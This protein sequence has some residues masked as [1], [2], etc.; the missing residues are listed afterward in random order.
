MLLRHAVLFLIVL[1]TALTVSAWPTEQFIPGPK[2]GEFGYPPAGYED[3]DPGTVLKVKKI[4]P[5][6][7]GISKINATGYKV[8]YRSSARSPSEPM[9]ATMMLLV[10]HNPDTGKVI[11][12]APPED[13]PATECAPSNVYKK[14]KH[15]DTSNLFAR[16]DLLMINVHLQNGMVVIVPDYEGPNA[17]F[18]VGT[19]SGH[20]ILDAARAAKNLPD[21][22]LNDNV[23]FVAMGYSGGGFAVA[24]AAQLHGSYANDVNLVGAAIG[25]APV[26]VTDHIVYND[27]ERKGA[28]II[29]AMTG[30]FNGNPDAAREVPKYFNKRGLAGMYWARSHCSSFKQKKK[31]IHLKRTSDAFLKGGRKFADI[32]FLV[33][34]AEKN[35]LGH[36]DDSAPNVPVFMYHI[37]DDDVVPYKRA[38]EVAENWCT[39][40]GANVVFQ[41]QTF[42]APHFAPFFATFAY[43]VRFANARFEGKEFHGGSCH[44]STTSTPAFNIRD[45]VEFIGHAAD[46]LKTLFGEVTNKH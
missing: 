10:P 2:K 8:L 26:N 20:A 19:I 42:P 24:W 28:F 15:F 14:S 4:Q 21:A 45:D 35:S 43:L 18:S 23:K 37:K 17:A 38:K 30:I 3:K 16:G 1:V 36:K 22:K 29:N 41:T 12:H 39:K 34:L 27:E 46:I 11:I 25:G 31:N 5:Y 7:V 33:D 13:A 40:D 44:F 6:E 32:P 9:A